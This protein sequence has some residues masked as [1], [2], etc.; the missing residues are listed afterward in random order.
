MADVQTFGFSPVVIAKVQ[1][2]YHDIESVLKV[3][4][5]LSAQREIRDALCPVKLLLHKELSSF[6][7]SACYIVSAYADDVIVFIH[8]LCELQQ[9]LLCQS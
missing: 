2:L 4:S 5:G 6:T 9:T 8:R 7:I 1:L 3:N